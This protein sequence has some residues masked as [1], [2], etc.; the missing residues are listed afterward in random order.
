MEEK[1]KIKLLFY[2]SDEESQQIKYYKLSF[3][4]EETEPHII[5]N[6]DTEAE[7]E[8]PDEAFKFGKDKAN[9]FIKLFVKYGNVAHT[10][11]YQIYYNFNNI[12]LGKEN[13]DGGYNVELDFRNFKELKVNSGKLKFDSFDDNNTKERKKLTLLNYNKTSIKVNNMVISFKDLIETCPIKSDFYRISIDMKGND[14]KII[15]QPLEEI[16][17]PNLHVLNEIKSTIEKFYKELSDSIENDKKSNNFK[18]DY[19]S[20][21]IKYSS[22]IP[23]IFYELNKSTDYLEKYFEENIIDLDIVFKYEIFRLFKEFINKFHE[24]DNN[25]NDE[26]DEIEDDEN[27]EMNEVDKD[28]ENN[29]IKNELLINFFEEIHKLYEQIKNE[30]LKIYEKIGLLVKINNIFLN[31]EDMND[32]NELNI[33]YVILSN[34][35]SGSILDKTKKMFKDFISNLNESSKIFSYLLNVD[36]GAGYYN[37][38][39]VFTFDMTN[40]NTLKNHLEDIFPKVILFYVLNDNNLGNTDKNTG[41]IAINL[42]HI[43]LYDDD[44]N[45]VVFDQKLKDEDLANEIAITIFLILLHELTGH[46]KF[47]YNKNSDND[48]PKKI[49]DEL[50]NLIEFKRSSKYKENDSDNEYLL[51]SELS[52]EG[53]GESGIFIEFAF[54]KEKNDLLTQLLIFLDDKN[55]LYGRTDLFVGEN[56]DILKKYVILRKTAENKHIKITDL[57]KL[58]IEEQINELEKY[59]QSLEFVEEKNEFDSEEKKNEFDS[60]EK[61]K[62]LL[63]KKRKIKKSDYNNKGK[64]S[65]KS[66]E[67]KNMKINKFTNKHKKYELEKRQDKKSKNLKKPYYNG[68]KERFWKLYKYFR[69]KYGFKDSSEMKKGIRKLIESN[70]VSGQ[71]LFDL[72]FVFD[73]LMIAY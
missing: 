73:K 71:E 36:S 5:N 41:C 9:I 23:S 52:E 32:F 43:N 40:L 33:N 16:K 38:E 55:K 24:E 72:C 44:L 70:S 54:G 21:L 34:C 39:K 53:K 58:D 42:N 22:K 27:S 31:C 8:V 37:Q 19:N 47:L 67:Q 17:E 20:I 10:L 69:E 50:N 29:E 62:E 3:E 63:G 26:N 56:F 68:V 28:N 14:T 18:T 35:Q 6:T 7:Y 13:E 1:P 12:Y 4:N 30:K 64:K 48:T 2:A 45:T 59:L 11:K 51:S 65:K 57:K 46:K 25:K 15:V 61:K 66:E 60:E 49:F